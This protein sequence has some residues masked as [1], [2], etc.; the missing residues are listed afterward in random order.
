M[1]SMLSALDW[2]PRVLRSKVKH[3][4][5]EWPMQVHCRVGGSGGGKPRELL[6]T[7]PAGKSRLM[8]QLA[9][10]LRGPLSGLP[11]LPGLVKVRCALL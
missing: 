7:L 3:L 10:A 8:R 6:E 1:A 9:R 2:R 5:G 4:L 11:Q